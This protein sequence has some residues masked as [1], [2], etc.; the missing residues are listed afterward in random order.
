MHHAS[1]YTEGKRR[2]RSSMIDQVMMKRTR[3]NDQNEGDLPR[4]MRQ[5][6]NQ[7]AVIA[8][9]HPPF[10]RIFCGDLPKN[11]SLRS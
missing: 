10:L 7:G 8:Q 1:Y 2:E 3:T 9:P 5:E 11:S 6:E 4:I